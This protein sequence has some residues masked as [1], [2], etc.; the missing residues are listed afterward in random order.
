MCYQIFHSL[1]SSV[2][3]GAWEQTLQPDAVPVCSWMEIKV[4]AIRQAGLFTG[5]EQPRNL[6]ATVMD[7]LI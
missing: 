3:S 7:T 1:C 2:A 6:I 5:A 4:L